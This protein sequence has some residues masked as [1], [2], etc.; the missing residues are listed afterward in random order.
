MNEHKV[1]D[2]GN[3]KDA[4]YDLVSHIFVVPQK[5]LIRCYYCLTE[6]YKSTPVCCPEPFY[7]KTCGCY[8]TPK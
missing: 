8:R 1:S 6:H 4:R 5:T 3:S 7:S 2:R